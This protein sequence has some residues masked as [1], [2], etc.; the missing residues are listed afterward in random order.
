MNA[1]EKNMELSDPTMTAG[2]ADF[3]VDLS[4]HGNR[5]IYLTGS[6]LRRARRLL[7]SELLEQRQLG[8]RYFGVTRKGH[9]FASEVRRHRS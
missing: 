6:D 1:T 5:T 9:R 8:D 3:I 7:S 4:R 2:D